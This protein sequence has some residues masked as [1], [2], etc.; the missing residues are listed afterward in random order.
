MMFD[1]NKKKLK[2]AFSK[3]KEE[4]DEHR[5]AINSNTNELQQT[6]E[7]LDKLDEK[8]DKLQEKIETLKL[9][10]HEKEEESYSVTSLTFREKE[11]FLVLYESEEMLTYEEIAKKLGL[12][13]E[14]VASYVTNLVIKGVPVIKKYS[15]SII[16]VILDS[17][18]KASQAKRN[19]IPLV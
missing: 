5:E 7:F 11:V 17:K 4:L 19:I 16:Y 13:K 8:I 15:D 12:T 10:I 3:I 9:S 18:F 2:E 1:I 6:Q 14:L